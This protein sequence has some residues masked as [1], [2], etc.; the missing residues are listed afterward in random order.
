MS[1]RVA[2]VTRGTRGLGLLTARKLAERGYRVVLTGRD[3]NRAMAACAGIQV[4][5]PFARIEWLR[6]DTSSL[7]SVRAFVEAFRALR[8]PLHLLVNSAG[9][10]S[11]Q[12]T[13]RFTIDGFETTIAANLIGPFLLTR[14]LSED[15]ERSSPSRVVVV[16][17]QLHEKG[18]G[19]GPGPEF[20]WDDVLHCAKGFNPVVAYRNAQLAL[21]WFMSGLSQQLAGR[22][23]AVNAV[24]PG[25]L[26]D[27]Q[28]GAQ[29][30]VWR[31]IL[32]EHIHP[33][34]PFARTA[35][36]AAED[37]L[38]VAT[39]QH[40]AGVTGRLFT[41]QKECRSSDDSYPHEQIERLFARCERWCDLEG[42]L[43]APR[44]RI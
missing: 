20:D 5:A 44:L 34:M 18:G 30:T 39:S 19:A 10:I 17:S 16:A 37:I 15:L 7:H 4:S 22:Q 38:F 24:C 23:V 29:P 36:E 21:K 12:A 9:G 2:I 42:S 13:P 27:T 11:P 6:L 41:D 1:E 28:L 8:Q 25:F 35:E 43:L 26:P 32:S 31:R 3:A 14:L 33:R 40:L